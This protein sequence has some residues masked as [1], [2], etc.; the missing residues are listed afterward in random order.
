MMLV[1]HIV[2]QCRRKLVV[3]RRGRSTQPSHGEWLLLYD[4]IGDI[5]EQARYRIHAC[6]LGYILIS[7]GISYCRGIDYISY[8]EV[9][10]RAVQL[11]GQRP[12]GIGQRHTEG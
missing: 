4:L 12:D 3:W 8:G 5:G 2:I 11:L 9:E 10:A 6:L 1:A 7:D